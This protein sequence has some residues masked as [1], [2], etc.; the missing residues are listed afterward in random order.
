MKI[1]FVGQARVL[2]G[3]SLEKR[4]GALA[5]FFSQKGH[6]VFATSATR[7]PK[8]TASLQAIY[9][10]SFSPENP[11]GRL[12]TAFSVL[13]A[14]RSKS[15]VIHFTTWKAVAYAY[16]VSLIRPQTTLVWTVSNMPNAGS[17]LSRFV[18]WQAAKACD[19]IVVPTRS[20]QYQMRLHFGV[21][22]AYVPDGYSNPALADIPAKTWN[23]RKGLYSLA[24][25][26]SVKDAKWIISAYT[27]IK[28]QKQLIVVL[29]SI[30]RAAKALAAKYPRI[31]II[32]AKGNRQAISLIRQAAVTIFANTPSSAE[33]ILH[34]MNAKN[35][36]IAINDPL[37]SEVLATAG[38]VIRKGDAEYLEVLLREIVK[39]PS[40]QQLFGNA[41]HAR[42]FAHFRWA[43]LAEEYEKFYHYPAV[44][45]VPMDS[46]QPSYKSA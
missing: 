35:A 5:D 26:D 44:R 37:Y 23:V 9:R 36:V 18:V 45:L 19:A 3:S 32:E 42:A 20:L 34:A 27:A 25:A 8:K 46:I 22:P 17:L 24:F 16:I 43:R 7:E 40:T 31:Q 10:A 21:L 33:H 1:T 14:I 41:A 11:G 38:K 39:T 2:G 28:T 15:D 30:T 29:P 12:F 13:F 6:A 4:I